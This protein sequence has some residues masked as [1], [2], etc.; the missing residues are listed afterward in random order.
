MLKPNPVQRVMEK[1][2][3][4]CSHMYAN[5]I[6]IS[7]KFL[8][9]VLDLIIENWHIPSD[10][11]WLQWIGRENERKGQVCVLVLD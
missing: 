1:A 9:C 2:G 11:P 7:A 6:H 5:S 10:M 3:L 8:S 4:M